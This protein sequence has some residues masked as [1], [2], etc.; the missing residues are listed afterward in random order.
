[1]T[2]FCLTYLDCRIWYNITF[3][4]DLLQLLHVRTIATT[5]TENKLKKHKSVV[6]LA[7]RVANGI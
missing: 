5:E 6:I 1:M 4:V 2:F 7:V 3:E